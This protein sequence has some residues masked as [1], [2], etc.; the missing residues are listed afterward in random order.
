MAGRSA[1]P[2]VGQAVRASSGNPRSTK[3]GPKRAKAGNGRPSRWGSGTVG[4]AIRI[5]MRGRC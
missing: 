5:A 2:A 3:A 1:S 4:K